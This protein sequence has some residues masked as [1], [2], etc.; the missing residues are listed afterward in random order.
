MALLTL[1]DLKK[2]PY[3][4]R[5]E[6]LATF[7]PHEI[8]VLFHNWDFLSRP[9]QRPPP[10]DW[11]FWLY[12]AG[13]G[14]GKTRTGAETCRQWVK[15]GYKRIGMIA[16]TAGDTRDVM[17]E[18]E[19][20][21]LA[22]AF[23][24]DYDL[25]GQ[26]MGVPEYEPSKR[27][28]TWQNGAIASLYS[29]D[30]PERLRGPQHDAMWADELA[31]WR[32]PETWDLAMFG[33]RLGAKPR[34]FISTTPKPVKLLLEIMK[35]KVTVTTK[36][37]TYDN[38][39]NLAPSFF[40]Q[41]ITKYEG[42]RLGKQELLAEL[43]MEAESALWNRENIDSTRVKRIPDD[44]WFMRL[45]VALDPATT[46]KDTSDETGIIIAGL[47]SD[48][49]TYVLKDLSGRYSPGEWANI[50][51]K[52]YRDFQ[53]DAIVAESNQGGDMVK[54]TIQ[55]SDPNANVKLVRASKG[56]QARAEPVAALWEKGTAHLVGDFSEL[57]DQLVQWEPLSGKE[58]PDRLDALVWAVTETTIAGQT[59]GEGRINN[60]Y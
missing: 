58:S 16:P 60:A 40:E 38:R 56:K 57:E 41:V 22:C 52:A 26:Y 47:G 18:G 21:V 23:K 43:L 36:G 14:A 2:L 49:H 31:S 25:N 29:A 28:L 50:A 7:S 20:G 34:A 27:R 8:D 48:W 3:E 6:F 54:H 51:V 42:T 11:S 30:E 10:G 37:S 33:L 17:V 46:N 13:R 4:K 1:Q 12:L 59:V 5:E 32:R 19:S 44:V 39:D 15:E 9:E 53:C 55:T 24:G 35:N 45:V